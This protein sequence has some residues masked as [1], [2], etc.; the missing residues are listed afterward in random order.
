[1]RLA[2]IHRPRGAVRTRAQS[3]CWQTCL[4]EV[5]F[6]RTVPE[7]ASFQEPVLQDADAYALLLEIVCGLRSPLIG[8]T[9]V[10]AQFKAF[11]AT[12]D[13]AT[14]GWL[15]R[16]GERILADA[17]SIRRQYL[18][19]FGAHSYGWL[20]A[21]HLE[22]ERVAVVG[23]G[24]LAR[25]VLSHLPPARPVD[26]WARRRDVLLDAGVRATRQL[27]IAEAGTEGEPTT[28][29]TTI[30]VAAPIDER[31][32]NVIVCRYRY[33]V[34]IIDLRAGDQQTPI[35]ADAPVLPL[36]AL[37]AEGAAMASA[38]TALVPAAAAAEVRRRA[39][40]FASREE[41]RPFGWDDLC[42]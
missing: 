31:D 9:E 2:L 41:L 27:L 20:A 30:V 34:R 17:K 24:A 29:D 13:P 8:E 32:L 18:Q 4:R 19:G 1:M 7:A 3:T 11:M 21:R 33:V 16:L 37:L 12:L 5:Q 14:D 22:G 23:T 42:A 10:Q 39:C 35:A 6:V 15:R 36:S 26:I 38:A 25:Q 28:E 40:A